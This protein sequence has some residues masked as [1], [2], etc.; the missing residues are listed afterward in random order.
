VKS[1]ENFQTDLV[2]RGI[3]T[4]GIKP[5]EFLFQRSDFVR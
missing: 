4:C 5:M 3:G 1:I 2:K